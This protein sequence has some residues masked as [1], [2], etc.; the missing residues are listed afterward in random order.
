VPL[1]WL[2]APLCPERA[3]PEADM[4]VDCAVPAPVTWVN[5]GKGVLAGGS[6]T[7]RVVSVTVMAAPTVAVAGAASTALTVTGGML[8]LEPVRLHE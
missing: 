5:A 3:R 2:L 4:S 6:C 7:G 8:A 1:V